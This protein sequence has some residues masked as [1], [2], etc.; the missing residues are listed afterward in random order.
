[1]DA[2]LHGPFKVMN[3]MSPTAHKLELPSQ[4]RIPN[5]FHASLIEP[6]RIAS[7]PIRD[8]PDLNAIVTAE[9]ELGYDDE[10]YGY[11]TG[12][13]VEEIMG[14]QFNKEWKKVLYLVKW[15]G[16][17]DTTDRIEE[18]YENFDHK[19]LLKEFHMRNPQA[20]KDKRL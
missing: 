12:Y 2:K 15:K 17:P 5:A 9:H 11:Q 18:P 16:Y 14:S 10:G 3:V 4:W 6:C 7:I 19:K 1:L 13:E 20:A 8:P